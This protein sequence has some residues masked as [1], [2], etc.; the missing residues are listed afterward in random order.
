MSSKKSC[1]IFYTTAVTNGVAVTE[2]VAIVIVRAPVCMEVFT[3]GISQI[4]FAFAYICISL[5]LY[6]KKSDVAWY[7]YILNKYFLRKMLIFLNIFV[8]V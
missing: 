4:P 1:G 2:S 7:R 6:V 8:S 3:T 5:S